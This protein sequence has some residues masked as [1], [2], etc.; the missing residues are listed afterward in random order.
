MEFLD[1][2]LIFKNRF[3]VLKHLFCC[4]GNGYEWVDG[5]LV[6][7]CKE[8]EEG[9]E[10][11][12]YS[13]IDERIA[14]HEKEIAEEDHSGLSPIFLI[15]DRKTKMD[16]EYTEEHIEAYATSHFLD[17]ETDK[18]R[19]IHDA[20]KRGTYGWAI[21]PNEKDHSFSPALPKAEDLDIDFRTAIR[22]FAADLFPSFNMLYMA[23]HVDYDKCYD[24]IKD[25]KVLNLLHIL[26]HCS[27]LRTEEEQK[28]Y[29]E[30]NSYAMKLTEKLLKEL[31]EEEEND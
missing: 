19:F 2:Y 8:E 7:V 18:I 16:M 15:K 31:K 3:Q 12:D 11:M 26:Q 4:N 30:Q 28:K 17:N 1:N 9:L 6:N 27:S 13:Y 23:T 14:K 24:H 21:S 10:K 22:K 20:V 25:E 5:H 29:E